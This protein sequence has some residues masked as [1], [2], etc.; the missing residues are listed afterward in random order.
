[1]KIS[2][3]MTYAP[4]GKPCPVVKPGEFL[5]SAAHLDH[6]HIYGMVGA[7]IE[8]G[9]TLKSVYDPQPERLAKFL[10][11]YP[12]A[13]AVPSEEALLAD[14]ETILVAGAHI[15]SERGPFGCRVMAAGKD[16]F[17]DKAPFTTLEQLEEAK[18]TAAATG[19][20]YMVYYSERLHVE[21]AILAG[22]MI[23]QGEIGKVIHVEGLGP[24][25]LGAAGRPAWFF[26]KE[27]YGGIL[28]DIGSHQI[29]QYLYFA[30]EEDARVAYSRIG[31]YANPDH[32][33]LDDF[34]DCSIV[35]AKGS[36]NYF[37]VDWFTPDGLRTWGG[38]PYPHP[39]D[40]GIYRD[41][42]ICG[43]RLPT[44]GGRP[45]LPGQRAGRAVFRCPWRHR[46]PLL[47]A[48]D[49][50]LPGADGIGHDPGPRLQG[51][52]ALPPR[53]GP[54]RSGAVNPSVIEASPIGCEYGEHDHSEAD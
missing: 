48:V 11:T 43:H 21:G 1:M 28:C 4:K 52:R 37:R 30:G 9:G 33:E 51:R 53:P 45:C 22:Y 5:F 35:G 7:L 32:P 3:G 15:T 27:K 39:G 20:K 46:L 19:R 25:R 24:H 17:T 44:A 36:T 10:K 13:V 41:T 34:G 12:Q 50:G 14:P 31:N 40:G 54:G 38:R 26:E 47:R 2:D 16:Y 29:E 42:K 49:P 23:E 8:A 18:R 6:G